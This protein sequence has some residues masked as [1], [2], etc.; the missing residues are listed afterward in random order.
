MQNISESKV[1]A[2]TVCIKEKLIYRAVFE[3]IDIMRKSNL[4][5]HRNRECLLST[6]TLILL[7]LQLP[8]I[9]KIMI[10]L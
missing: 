1:C 9:F 6:N 8:V 4:P 3:I 10:R 2:T 5:Y 7:S